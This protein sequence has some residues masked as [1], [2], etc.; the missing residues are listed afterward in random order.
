MSV[1]DFTEE[2]I[3][4]YS[5]QILLN[6]IGGEGQGKLLESGALVVGAGG[7]GSPALLYLAGAGVG[8]LGVVD[9]DQVD[10]SNLHRQVIHRTPDQGRS[11]TASAQEAVKELNPDCEVAA[12]AERL[13]TGNIREIVRGFDIVLD[14]SDNFPTR[15]LVSD[16]CRFE[17]LPLVSAAAV[18][19]DGQ[20]MTI[21][22]ERGQ[23][24]YR[25]FLAEP[26]PPGLT[27]R[28]QEAGVLG[29]VTGV[30]GTLQAAE[31]IKILLG[32][33][34]ALSDRMLIYDALDASFLTVRRAR[35]A[36]CP[37]CGDDPVITDLVGYGPDDCPT[38]GRDEH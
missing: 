36:S 38:G 14:G 13:E 33:G 16:C 21:L 35:A 32:I 22:P 28:C 20:L 27:P 2:Q 18:Q 5:R 9:S 24:C 15:F 11:K 30:M 3:E 37:L 17:G 12:F 8:R 19:F 34:A 4:R 10:L 6:E 31:A 26:P 29:V 25:C 7:L 23:P 1:Y